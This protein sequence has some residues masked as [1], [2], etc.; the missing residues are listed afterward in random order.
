MNE[1]LPL[2]N[3]RSIAIVGASADLTKVNGRTLKY[4]VEK[5]Y[6]GNIY[7]VNPKYPNI[8]GLPCYGTIGDLPEAADLAVIA[9]PAA[10]VASAVRDLGARGIKSAVVF[11][12]GFAETGGEG[13][14]LEQE[15]R[16][17]IRESGVR[18]LGPN[19]LGLINAFDRIIA[20]FGQFA[21]G[22]VAAGPVAFVTQSGAFGTA[23][24][25]LARRRDLGLGYFVNTGNECDV[26]FVDVMREVLA[27]P[28]I[29]VGAGYLE[30]LRDGPG[31]SELAAFALEAKTPLVLTKVGRTGAGARAAA[32]HTGALAGADMVFDGVVR[33]YG[34]V[35][36]RNEEH[37]LDVVEAFAHCGLPDGDGIG[38]I[39]QSGGA[40]VLMADRAEE[41]GLKVPLLHEHTRRALQAVIPGFGATENPVD[42]T[43]QF[44]AE[45]GLLRESVRV[46]LADPQVHIGIVWLQLMDAHVDLLVDIF[47]EIK[48]RAVKPLIVCW[49]AAPDRALRALHAR[50]IAAL[51]G[52]EP[53]VDAAAALVYYGQA[54]RNWLVD[55]PARAGLAA[56][57]LAL[58]AGAGT[59]DTVSAQRLL[60]A[61]GVRTV[62][63]ELARSAE[64]AVTAAG[65]LGYP[66]A[67]KIESPEI[68]HKTEVGGVR[69]ALADAAAVR[70][71]Y[72]AVMADAQRYRPDAC[73]AGV[74]VQAM[75]RGEV[76]LVVGLQNDAVFGVVVMVGLGG[77][78]IEVLR[79]VVFRQ[80]P[81]T[82]AEAT[83]MLDELR[84]RA[85]LDGVRGRPG[86]DRGA[87][88]ELVSAV[89]RFGAAAGARLRECDL[90]PVL[91]GP[92][93]A[94]A[95]DWLAVL[96]AAASGT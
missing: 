83:R 68:L 65:R 82:R 57:R 23:I 29:R 16:T 20:T 18:V 26:S 91:A 36:A 45:P 60:E 8:G 80:A 14:R 39:T 50:G 79:D 86:V 71:A 72:A 43:G 46:V 89:S 59:V 85:L 34:I 93:G 48:A 70:A 64:D 81:V 95:V 24:A 13:R 3:P 61:C 55:A 56:P 7:P 11:S 30:G 58:P 6:A 84:G 15:L 76:E 66:V 47:E 77:I 25:A 51:R 2:L 49:V 12:S 94:V 52:A 67:L 32:S 90:N 96:D 31:L 5:G 69:L 41:L 37:M 9:L 28:R 19:C 4:L 92:D 38:I 87:V 74:V 73:I 88:A 44:V 63:C 33:G 75:A 1:L 40:G 62:R 22:E 35:R 10:L 27:D 17:A 42:V 78:H 53:A 54:R 21:E